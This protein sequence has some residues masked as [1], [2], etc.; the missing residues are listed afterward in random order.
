[1]PRRKRTA[2]RKER[3]A[4]ELRGLTDEE[5]SW[6]RDPSGRPY[7]F[8]KPPLPGF[9][10]P[11]ATWLRWGAEMKRRGLAFAALSAFETEAE[12][13]ARWAARREVPGGD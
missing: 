7:A 13:E 11:D 3:I 10:E 5:L 8:K 6:L 2:R 1:M 4:D 12:T 9:D